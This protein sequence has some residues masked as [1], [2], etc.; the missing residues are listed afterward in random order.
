MKKLLIILGLMLGVAVFAHAQQ[1]GGNRGAWKPEDRVKMLNEK[2]KLSDD[3]KAKLTAIFTAQ[4]DSLQKLRS[5]MKDGDRTAMRE[6]M[7]KMRANSDAQI[8]AVLN[9]DQK[10][11]YKAMQEEQRAQMK[12]RMQDRQNQ[13]QSDNGAG[14]GMQ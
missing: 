8:N 4:A 1:V 10:K 12:K 14:G 6:K 11:T 5:D 2:L 13:G 9:D 7:Q 3:Q